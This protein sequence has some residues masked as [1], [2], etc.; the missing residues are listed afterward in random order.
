MPSTS[1]KACF[2]SLLISAAYCQPSRSCEK[3]CSNYMTAAVDT[4]GEKNINAPGTDVKADAMSRLCRL[5]S[6]D[7]LTCASCSTEIFDRSRTDRQRLDSWDAACQ[8]LEKDGLNQALAC[9]AGLPDDSTACTHW[10]RAST[11]SEDSQ[12][13]RKPLSTSSSKQDPLLFPDQADGLQERPVGH[14]RVLDVTLSTS[15]DSHRRRQRRSDRQREQE[16][17]F[18]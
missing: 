5:A 8:T 6:R 18:L 16:K 7:I 2:F 13:D 3:S 17:H 9:W 12:S 1:L 14:S 10:E 15:Q 4:F 11:I